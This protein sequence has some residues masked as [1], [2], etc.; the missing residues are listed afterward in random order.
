M[1]ECSCPFG[2]TQKT[3]SMK[4]NEVTGVKIRSVASPCEKN[5][6]AYVHTEI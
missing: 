4:L 1:N 3:N 2:M 6:L 5:H